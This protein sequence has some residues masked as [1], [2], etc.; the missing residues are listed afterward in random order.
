VVLN[1]PRVLELGIRPLEELTRL[2]SVLSRTNEGNNALRV[3]ATGV[4]DGLQE[5]AI[6]LVY[7]GAVLSRRPRRFVDGLKSNEAA[8]A[9]Q[10][11][12]DLVP[13]RI[14]SLFDGREVCVSLSDIGPLSRV[15]VHVDDSVESAG[16][17][18][19]DDVGHAL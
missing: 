4:V 3:E 5:D 10:L 16:G 11:R 18:H 2:R 6:Q 19:I 14:E 13:Q 8:L 1:S 7:L 12:A 9:C 15:M 17:N